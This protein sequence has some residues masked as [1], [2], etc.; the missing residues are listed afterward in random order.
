MPSADRRAGR[1]VAL[2]GVSADPV[3]A[4]RLLARL[5]P[6]LRAAGVS[7][8]DASGLFTDL[9]RGAPQLARP[10][11]RTLCL[12][13]AADL[14]F[15]LRWQIQPALD[16]GRIVVAVPYVHTLVA[17]GRAAGLPQLW[18]VRLLAFAPPAARCYHLREPQGSVPLSGFVAFSGRQI[19]AAA[20][21]EAARRLFD[22]TAAA[23]EGLARRRR[24]QGWR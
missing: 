20:S 3:A 17:F 15:R 18:L 11:P 23:L 24:C 5:T 6:G 4:R 12:L 13:Y 9:E 7:P 1:L 14:A 19:A 22:K 2:E 21:P 16:A 10:S 8:W